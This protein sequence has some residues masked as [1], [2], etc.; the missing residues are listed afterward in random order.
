MCFGGCWPRVS[1]SRVI[2]FTVP[3]VPA[4]QGS[5]TR[6]GTEDNPRT[7]PWRAAVAI[8][9]E[10]QPMLDGP[11]R[12]EVAFVFPR[13][14]NHYGTGRNAG[15]LKRD[16]ALF[17]NTKPDLDK[18]LRAIGDALTGLVWRDDSQVA[19]VQARKIYGEQACAVITVRRIT[20]TP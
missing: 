11:L 8:A 6:W 4:P 18:L 13:P 10:G 9:A 1:D 2:S 5:K 16:V 20:A 12:L 15:V 19:F 14:K 7:K 17:H 3:G